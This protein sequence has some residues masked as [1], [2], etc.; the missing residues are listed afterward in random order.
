MHNPFSL[1]GK[2]ILVT[3]ASSGIG[4]SIAIECSKLGANLI[5]TGRNEDRLRETLLHLQSGEHQY[6]V[7]DITIEEDIENLV[8]QLP[9]V[10]VAYTV[11]GFLG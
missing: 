6:I 9:I 7:A 4:R 3:G 11:L 8:K 2:T 5:I 1:I 10:M